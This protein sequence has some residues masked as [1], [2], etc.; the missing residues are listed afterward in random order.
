MDG[1]TI[2]ISSISNGLQ[3]AGH[4]VTVAAIATPKHPAPPS[5]ETGAGVHS[6]FVDTRLK[7]RAALVNFLFSR[8]PFQITRFLSRDFS[9]LLQTLI[10]QHQYDII[11]LEGL[12]LSE[13]LPVIRHTTKAP[14]LMRSHN[15]EHVIW[16]GV[17][18]TE[19]NPLRKLYLKNLAKRIKRYELNHLNDY[20][21]MVPLT[22]TD[23]DF[24]KDSG[25]TIPILVLPTGLSLNDYKQNGVANSDHLFILASWDWIP[26]QDGLSWFLSTVWPRL[27][28][29]L[30]NL[31]LTIAG[32]NAPESI[33]SIQED[34]VD[35]VGEIE[36]PQQLY[37]KGGVMIVPLLSGSG[38]R[39]KIIEAMAAGVPVVSTAIGAQGISG[40]HGEHFLVADD[41]DAF[42]QQTLECLTDED[43]RNS[44]SANAA[45]FARTHFDVKE[46]TVR[47]VEFYNRLLS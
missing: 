13:Y 45:A 44:L 46:T 1:E 18:K 30:S 32:R 29:Q 41:P 27:R 33:R 20:D 8:Q 22:Q 19:S 37:S 31:R 14:V 12:A 42:A 16:Q 26:N 35:F 43:L 21:G 24:F 39:I 6:V 28:S 5:S 17:A 47:L 11:Q 23:A 34:G 9:E 38:L 25:C 10:R 40:I 36:S 2:A 7:R 4:E 15:V 3:D